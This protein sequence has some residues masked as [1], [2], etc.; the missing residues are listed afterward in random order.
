MAY[1]LPERIQ[2]LEPYAPL[3]GEFSIRL[4]AN[5]SFL[6]LPRALRQ[7][8]GETLADLDLNRYPD[9]RAKALCDAFAAY[10]G[11]P[12]GDN[13]VAG[14]GSD[15]LIGLLVSCFV[16]PGTPV[17]V[18]APDFSMYR[19]YAQLCGVPVAC[20]DKTGLTLDVDG[21]I[22]FCREQNPSLLLLSN[23][24]NPTS[25]LA[26]RADLLRLVEA[27]P[28]CLVAVDEAYMDF[29]QGSV[30]DGV[31]RYD[32]LLVLRTCSKALGLA[33]IR[34]GFAVAS[35]AVTRALLAVKSPYNVS[36]LTQAAGRVLFAHPNYLAECTQTI[37]ESRD[38]LY[39]T[40]KPLVRPAGLLRGVQNT[41]ANFVFVELPHEDEA[42]EL[43]LRAA[44]EGIAL[45][46]MGRFV[47][48]TAGTAQEN[49]AVTELLQALAS[50]A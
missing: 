16:R 47:R 23:P 44:R 8:L 10:Y 31:E 33:G 18:T 30:L 46:K 48:I 39:Q 45:R 6:R 41:Q 27:L 28:H 3:E 20:F 50:E 49:K 12:D 19:F 13:V 35:P 4:D 26:G 21:L 14:N 36:S 29:A 25:L 37:R 43:F 32:N 15:E 38:S 22:A 9:P 34:L 1:T 7:E 24:C 40:V 17:A 2:S 11:L 42:E 5:E